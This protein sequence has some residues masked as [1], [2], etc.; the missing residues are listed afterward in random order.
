MGGTQ[1][2]A[3]P[4]PHVRELADGVPRSRLE[5]LECGHLAAEA[6]APLLDALRGHLSRGPAR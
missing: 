1:D 2:V 4:L 5:V 3:T 6:S